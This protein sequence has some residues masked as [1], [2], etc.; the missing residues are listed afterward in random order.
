MFYT[1]TLHKG[2]FIDS[3]G[4]DYYVIG[5][6]AD[7]QVIVIHIHCIIRL[8]QKTQRQRRIY[9]GYFLSILI[10]SKNH[11]STVFSLGGL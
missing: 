10:A 3:L 4:R 9:P 6:A 5:T 1:F 8:K 7:I 11:P 2:A